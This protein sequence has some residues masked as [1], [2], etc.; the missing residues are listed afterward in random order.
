MACNHHYHNHNHQHHDLHHHQQ[1]HYDLCNTNRDRTPRGQ[2]R[3]GSG[4]SFADRPYSAQDHGFLVEL[5][6]DA[7]TE[8]EDS[9]SCSSS[10]SSEQNN[11]TDESSIGY[12]WS[13]EDRDRS[14]VCSPFELLLEDSNSSLVTSNHT[15]HLEDSNSSFQSLIALPQQPLN[16]RNQRGVSFGDVTV[17][18]YLQ[19]R[20]Q[21]T[22]AIT[23]LSLA[24]HELT[25]FLSFSIVKLVS[26][27]SEQTTTTTQKRMIPSTVAHVAPTASTM[28]D[29]KLRAA[30][31]MATTAPTGEDP[32][33]V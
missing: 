28:Q 29:S 1:H 14:L 22:A 25:R 23:R 31:S 32:V 12:S 4:D 10:S 9:C 5:A 8:D 3:R 11:E 7:H 15:H 6:R 16:I 2:Q 13:M 17:Y 33:K 21:E 18:E 30:P 27:T 26:L 20:H 24:Q 19:Q